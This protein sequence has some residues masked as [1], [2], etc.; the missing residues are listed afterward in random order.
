MNARVLLGLALALALGAPRAGRAQDSLGVL[1]L[2]LWHNQ[3]DWPGRLDG[4][5]REATRLRADVVLLQEVLQNDTLENQATTLGRRL[6]LPHVHFV[7]VDPAGAAKRYGNAIVSRYPFDTTA[8]RALL[9]RDQYRTAAFARVRVGAR[10]VDVVTTHLHH[11]PDAAG[12][13]IRAMQLVDLLA[14]VDSSATGAPLVVGGD[15]NAEPDRPELRLMAPFRDLGRAFGADG[16]TWGPAY[17]QGRARRIDYLFDR[18]D[19]RL[20]PG[21][22]AVVMDRADAAGRYPSDHFGVFARFALR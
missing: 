7:S 16:P 21:S 13:G 22:V 6:G 4:V 2:N 9:P 12:G 10:A 17:A 3:R 1:T 11:E 14:F 5:V 8:A 15:L 20:V 18:A 19:P